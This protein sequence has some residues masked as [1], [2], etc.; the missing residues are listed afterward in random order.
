[1][2]ARLVVWELPRMLADVVREAFAAEPDVSVQELTVGPDELAAAV[3]ATRP[4]I[5]I[6]GISE[7]GE[8]PSALLRHPGPIVLGLS[9]SGRDGWVCTLR[10]HTRR[11][12]ELSLQTLRGA[13]R[14]ALQDR[15]GSGDGLR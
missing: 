9:V 8:P 10:P 3:R 1:V 15:G 14:E 2:P 6:V 4:D 5:M 13:V 7:G 12:G 11:L